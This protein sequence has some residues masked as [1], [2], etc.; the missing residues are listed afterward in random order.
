MAE[1]YALPV[2]NSQFG[3]G[4]VSSECIFGC[5]VI[6]PVLEHNYLDKVIDVRVNSRASNGDPGFGFVH[7]SAL[8]GLL[9]VWAL[10]F[11]ALLEAC[12]PMTN[13][14]SGDN[15]SKQGKIAKQN[16]SSAKAPSTGAE[17]HSPHP[18]S[19]DDVRGVFV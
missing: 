1:N 13:N 17:Q 19:G 7:Q 6:F 9:Q 18:N 2:E 12:P 8:V 15:K 3:P 4:P 14:D 10:V 11:P 5:I 16:D